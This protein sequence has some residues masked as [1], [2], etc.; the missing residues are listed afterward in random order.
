MPVYL[1]P[2][3]LKVK[4]SNGDYIGLNIFAE[5]S[6]EEVIESIPSD[7]TEL[8]GRVDDLEDTVEGLSA[9]TFSDANSDGQIVI[10]AVTAGGDS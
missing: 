6:V 4:D 10:T 1:K 5:R 8:D 7:Y 2:G 3:V 9:Y